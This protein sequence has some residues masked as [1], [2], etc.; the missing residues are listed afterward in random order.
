M[1]DPESLLWVRL[2]DSRTL[3]SSPHSWERAPALHQYGDVLAV[4][5]AAERLRATVFR[6]HSGMAVGGR[7]AGGL[8]AWPLS[9]LRAWPLRGHASHH[10][11]R[12][13]WWDRGRSKNDVR[14]QSSELPGWVC[15]RRS[16]GVGRFTGHREMGGGGA[17][18]GGT[19]RWGMGEPKERLEA[20]SA[21]VPLVP[22]P[23]CIP[24]R[25]SLIPVL[26]EVSKPDLGSGSEPGQRGGDPVAPHSPQGHGPSK[27][28]GQGRYPPGAQCTSAGAGGP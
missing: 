25:G 13:S 18:H 12:G 4:P 19:E 28:R 1:Q 20:L 7:L 27:D 3:L 8:L 14:E 5:P 21:A 26:G 16:G 2:H 9:G 24:G 11:G 6:L 10:P 22:P 23:M 15:Q 17:V